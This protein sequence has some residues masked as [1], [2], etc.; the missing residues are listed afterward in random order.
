MKIGFIGLG[1]MAGTICQGLIKSDFIDGSE[2]YGYDI[3]SQQLMMF[4]QDFGIH[5]CS[6]E[7]DVVKNCDYLVMGV[8]PNVVESVISKIKSVIDQQVIVSIVAGYGN[9]KYEELLPGTHHLTIMPN[10]PA[11]V[12]EGTTLFEKDNTLTAEELNYVQ[13]M[14]ESIGE[15]Y[16]IENYQMVAGGA[17]SG[18]G[19]AFVYMFIDAL[20]RAGVK[21]GM[22]KDQAL[23]I[24]TQSVLGSAKMIAESSEHPWELIDRVCSPGG[25]TIEGVLSL[26]ADGLETAVQ[27]AVDA[28]VEKDS[29]L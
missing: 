29:K 5:V 13:T 12:L 26:K 4:E 17:L 7:Q 3:N 23:Q 27:N 28:A 18:C 10:T 1:N 16:L 19:P 24:A 15:V 2:V 11:K 6:S 22:R 21:H 20:A 14:F 8:K 25:T 9:D